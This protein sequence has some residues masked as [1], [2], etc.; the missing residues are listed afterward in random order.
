MNKVCTAVIYWNV[1]LRPTN[2]LYLT[3]TNP[4]NL[5]WFGWLPLDDGYKQYA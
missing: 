2:G 5:V 1:D 4:G 3:E